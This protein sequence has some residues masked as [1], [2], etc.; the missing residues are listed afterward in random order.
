MTTFEPTGPVAAPAT[1]DRPFSLAG[2]RE[3]ARVDDLAGRLALAG[4]VA[5]GLAL[6]AGWAG[7]Q[8][9]A[10]IDHDSG[11]ILSFAG[12]WWAGERLYVDLIDVNPPL[13]FAL[14]LQPVWLSAVTG[15]SPPAAL[16]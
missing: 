3:I 12:R 16:T 4:M 7:L 13:V 2:I 1:S 11:A 5:F 15:T 9:L 14:N 8:F 10:P 6:A